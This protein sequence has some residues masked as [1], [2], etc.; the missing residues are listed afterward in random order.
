MNFHSIMDY[1]QAM[2]SFFIAPSSAKLLLGMFWRRATAP[3]GFWGL[4][5][6]MCTAIGIFL[7]TRSGPPDPRYV[8][9]SETASAISLNI[10]Q[11]A[12]SFVVNFMVT[13][14]VS[15]YTKPRPIEELAGW[16][17]GAS[18]EQA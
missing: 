15:L 6:G 13:V 2:F 8:T 18:G 16:I 7:T 3:E 5:C 12:W 11:A 10:W 17:F 9:L 14:L 4:S 1:M